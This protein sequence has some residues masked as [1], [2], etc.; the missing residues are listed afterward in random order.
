MSFRKIQE[1]VENHI[2]SAF[3][4]TDGNKVV[5]VIKTGGRG[6]VGF[7]KVDKQFWRAFL[8]STSKTTLYVD[9]KGVLLTKLL[10]ALK[11]K[12]F[13]VNIKHD[14]RVDLSLTTTPKKLH[15]MAF[16][17]ALNEASRF[18]PFFRLIR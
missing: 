7:S 13:S 4:S 11:L 10:F 1:Q 2:S 5:R 8:R 15:L 16:L 3:V 9:R 18:F 6:K 12:L 14:F 17:Y